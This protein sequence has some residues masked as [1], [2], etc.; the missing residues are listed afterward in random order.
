MHG[1]HLGFFCPY[2]IFRKGSH[3][4]ISYIVQKLFVPSLVLFP[5]SEVFFFHKLI[6][7]EDGVSIK[8]KIIIPKERPKSQN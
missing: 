1:G 8:E 3:A 5:F 6:G 4:I 2:W 7:L